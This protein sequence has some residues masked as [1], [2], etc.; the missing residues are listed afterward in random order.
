MTHGQTWDK[1]RGQRVGKLTLDWR[2]HSK[3][4]QLST[5]IPSWNRVLYSLPDIYDHLK[6]VVDRDNSDG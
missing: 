3:G 6:F 4:P 5:Q 1:A 2:E